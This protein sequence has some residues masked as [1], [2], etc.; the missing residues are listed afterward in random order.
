MSELS[1]INLL[2]DLQTLIENSRDRTAVAI[3]S[4]MTVL[5][6]SI[7][8]RINTDILREERAEYGKRTIVGISE[9]LVA[10]FGKGWGVQQLRHCM[11]FA[12][13]YPDKEKVYSLSRE[14]SWTHLR[15][16]MWIDDVQKRDFYTELAKREHWSTR[17]LRERINTLLFERTAISKKPE[18]TIANDLALLKNEGSMTPDL[19]FR[20]PYFL[21]YLGLQDTYSEYDLE[22]AILT[23]LQR[24]IIEIGSDFGFMAR[25]KRM[26]IDDRDYYLDLLFTHRRL[27]CLVAIELKLG[28]FE[29][30][31]K[32][33]MELYLRWLEKH[34]MLE[35]ENPPIGLILC[36]GKNT[37]HI[38][39]MGLD[40]SNIRVA[41]YL[42][43]L[44]DIK[45]LESKLRQSIQ[46][47]RSR[48]SDDKKPIEKNNPGE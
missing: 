26:T 24:F 35:G 46:V 45:L 10:R 22:S 38:E 21:D 37:E 33:Q 36:S 6:W 31:Y 40:D 3:N 29:A 44:P 14:L 27:R 17:L 15:T 42:T 23:E 20:D 16:L 19:V 32:G 34:E 47:A 4:E 28:E 25:Q 12:E 2:Q 5:Y 1:N 41:E 43:K 13:V 7:G 39:L 48:F 18:E 8:S 11:K 9:S 30:A